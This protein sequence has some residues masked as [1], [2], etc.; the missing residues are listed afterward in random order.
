MKILSLLGSLFSKKEVIEA[1]KE[2]YLPTF[3]IDKSYHEMN[4]REKREYKRWLSKNNMWD[5]DIVFENQE[6]MF[7]KD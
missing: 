7:F 3:H 1:A 6:K 5:G 4:R 2:K